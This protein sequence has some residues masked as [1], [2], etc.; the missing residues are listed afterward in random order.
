M[1]PVSYAS[2]ARFIELIGGSMGSFYDWYADLPPASPQVW[3]EQTDVPESADWFNA[4]YIINFGTNIPMTRTP[5]AQFFTEVRYKGTKIV[6]VSPDFS[7]HTRFADVWVPIK[8]GT[9]GAFALAMAHVILREYYVERQVDFFI[10]YVKSF[11]DLPFLVVLEPYEGGYRPG[12]FL[13]L[14]DLHPDEYYSEDYG[15]EPN[16]EWKL[17]IYDSNTGRPRLVNGSI[18]YRWDGSGKWNLKLEDPVTGGPVDPKLSFIDDSD[19]VV[20]V[21]FP[22]FGASF[23]EKG[24]VERGVP[25]KRVK[26]ADGSEAF[27]ATV[28]DLLAAYLGVDRGLPGDYPAGYDDKKPYTPAWQED[29]TGVSRELAI[30]LAREWADTA[31]RPRAGSWL[32]S[33][34]ALTTGST[35]T[36]TTG[37]Y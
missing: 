22:V 21:K 36:S 13:R 5:D 17:L 27:V 4:A 9:D 32:C 34:P 31:I 19:E 25:A 28:F 8:E 26:L 15:G 16:K 33:A 7:E 18:G 12:K 14:S 11:T 37:L 1:S 23:G 3:G 30:R 10:D 35:A 20:M 24:I 6:V 2:G 29:I